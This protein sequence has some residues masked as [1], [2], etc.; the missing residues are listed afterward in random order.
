LEYDIIS[1]IVSFIFETD[2]MPERVCWC[3]LNNTIVAI[4]L[5]VYPDRP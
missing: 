1:R 4:I 5:I 2:Y 3:I